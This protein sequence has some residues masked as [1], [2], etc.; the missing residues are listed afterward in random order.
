M[1][2]LDE[3]CRIVR[4]LWTQERATVVGEHFAVRDALCEPKPLQDPQR[5]RIR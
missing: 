2:M 1:D 3:A 4:A 5:Q